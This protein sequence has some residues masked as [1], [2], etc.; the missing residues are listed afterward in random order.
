MKIMITG[1]GFIGSHF[2][3]FFTEKGDDVTVFDNFSSGNEEFIKNKDIKLIRGDILDFD[4]LLDSMKGN[5]AVYHLAADPDVKGSY[6]NPM[7]SFQQ[8]VIGTQNVLEACR[9]CD[10]KTFVFASSSTVYGETENIPT[11][12]TEIIKPIS[13]YGSTKAA[14]ENMIMSYSHLYGIKGTILR[15]ANIIGP[16]LTHGVI[17][18][19]NGI[20]EC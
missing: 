15:F 18:E 7:G 1:G 20:K 13:T 19:R 9:K 16:R 10:V 5:D 14:S 2:V 12:E 8:N 3:D 17:F 4:I 6:S 11:P